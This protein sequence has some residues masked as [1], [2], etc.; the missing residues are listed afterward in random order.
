MPI[1]TAEQKNRDNRIFSFD[2][3]MFC[4][5]L[6]VG[7]AQAACSSHKKL[8]LST[9]STKTRSEVTR[10]RGF[11]QITLSA[12]LGRLLQMPHWMRIFMAVNAGCGRAIQAA[13]AVP[14]FFQRQDLDVPLGWGDLCAISDLSLTVRADET[15]ARYAAAS[16]RPQ[17]Q[18]VRIC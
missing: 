3:G 13:M 9:F 16:V 11:T 14:A 17:I 6:N 2:F 10:A 15:G 1:F 8:A 7:R 18:K 5:I 12:H 4:G